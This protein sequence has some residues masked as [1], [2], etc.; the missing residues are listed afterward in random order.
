ML[1]CLF[2]KNPECDPEFLTIMFDSG[3]DYLS[4]TTLVYMVESS[5]LM[6][7]KIINREHF[8]QYFFPHETI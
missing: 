1:C 4:T 7:L 6:T 5:V 8:I 3:I 2:P